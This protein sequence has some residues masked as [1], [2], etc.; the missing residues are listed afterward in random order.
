MY[1]SEVL[2]YNQLSGSIPDLS[3][4]TNLKNL[5]LSGNQLCRDN[6]IDYSQWSEAMEYP[7]CSEPSEPSEQMKKVDVRFFAYDIGRVTSNPPGIDCT[8][9]PCSAQFDVGTTITLTATP[10]SGSETGNHFVGWK[11]KK[12][13]KERRNTEPILTLNVQDS[14][15]VEATF[16]IERCFG[17]VGAGCGF[18]WDDSFGNKQYG[19]YGPDNDSNIAVGSILHDSCCYENPNGYKC[20]F[21]ESEPNSC[22]AEWD[23]AQNNWL[24]GR[25]WYPTDGDGEL[26]NFSEW[27]KKNRHCKMTELFEKLNAKL[28]EYYNYYGVRGNYKSL[29]SF[30]FH[31]MRILFKWLNRRSHRKSYNW[32]GFRELLKYFGIERP[33]ITEKTVRIQYKLFN[34]A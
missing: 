4:L 13:G 8:R 25:T 2:N 27:C 30:F 20:G 9:E 22:R 12:D 29:S 33:R 23:R 18:G 26:K 31:A 24:G 21:G 32:E 14:M 15:T 28:R 34:A 7:I 1:G 16:K 3:A 10:L 5:G 19:Q 17:A 6:N 11:W